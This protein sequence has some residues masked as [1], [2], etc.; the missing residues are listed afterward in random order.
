MKAFNQKVIDEFRSTGGQLTGFMAGR[1]VMLLTTIGARSGKPQTVVI[2]YGKDGDRF[3][4]VASNN[5]A[6]QDP[7]WY[8]NLSANHDVTVEVGA[9]KVRARA[10]TAKPEER[11]RLGELVPYLKTEQEKT[12]RPIPVVVLEPI[13]R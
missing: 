7:A 6:A 13:N 4:V 10:R 1:K 11:Q 8:R 2:G 12:D 5:G 9:D 3:V